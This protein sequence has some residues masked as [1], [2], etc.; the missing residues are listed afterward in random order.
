M[1]E[2]SGVQYGGFW[3]RLLALLADSAIVFV[4]SALLIASGATLL[5]PELLPVVI[6]VVTVLGLLYWPLMQASGRQ[7]TLGK[8]ILGLKVARLHGGRI[9]LLRSLGRELSKI[10][11]SMVFMLGYIIAAV[12][13]RKQALHDLV[14]STYVVREGVSRVVPAFA[15]VLA[16]FALPYVVVP[17]IA[18]AAVMS[19]MLAM[20]QG[21]AAAPDPMKALPK[22]PVAPKAPVLKA[23]PKPQPPAPVQTATVPETKPAAAEVK[24]AVVEA[25]PVALD[26]KPAAPVPP[27]PVAKTES[28]PKPAP[29]RLAKPAPAAFEPKVASGPKFNDLTTAVLYRDADGVTQLLKMGKWPDK[30]DSRGATPLMTAVELGDVRTA[31]A[32]LRGGA[33]PRLAMRSA[34]QRGDATMILLLKRYSR[35]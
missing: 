19:T 8:A 5:G 11:S 16:G 9:S 20:A 35:R 3:I 4:F 32:L 14:S 34:E 31:E 26:P 30:P 2:P 28:K 25:K 7:A 15:I 21:M 1:T 23:A 10:L 12:T 6:L 29:P 22:S 18:G 27:T 24:P 13:P 17:M 33:N